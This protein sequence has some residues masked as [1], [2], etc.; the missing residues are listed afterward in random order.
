[1]FW[2]LSSFVVP[3]VS[4]RYQN[5]ESVQVN[6]RH[7]RTAIFCSIAVAFAVVSFVPIFLTGS[8]VKII[9]VLGRKLSK[10]KKWQCNTSNKIGPQQSILKVEHFQGSV[11]AGSVYL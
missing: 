2:K 3:S 10:N 5:V 6:F 4:Y 11:T 7:I 1:L 9:S 8:S